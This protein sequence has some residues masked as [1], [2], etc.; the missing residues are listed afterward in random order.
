MR[1]FLEGFGLVWFFV[2]L[3]LFFIYLNFFEA[4]SHCVALALLEL[5][6]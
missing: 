3:L 2:C 5:T 6:L 4:W 1:W